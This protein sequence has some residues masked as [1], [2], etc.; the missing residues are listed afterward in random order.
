MIMESI[1]FL[2]LFSAFLAFLY[3]TALFYRMKYIASKAGYPISAFANDGKDPSPYV[4]EM[5]RNSPD[6]ASRN[7]MLRLKRHMARSIVVVAI[8]FPVGI[9]LM[10]LK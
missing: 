3:A 1:G 6:G 2:M 9:V 5:I 7:A 8:G 10:I 4:D